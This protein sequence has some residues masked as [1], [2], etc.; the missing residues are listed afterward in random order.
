MSNGCK[1]LHSVVFGVDLFRDVRVRVIS[2]RGRRASHR[3]QEHRIKRLGAGR[4]P[5][6][7]PIQNV[8]NQNKIRGS[9]IVHLNQ[10]EVMRRISG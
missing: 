5:L 1:E 4:I 10:E 2:E 9:K 7:H 8:C 3:E 6:H